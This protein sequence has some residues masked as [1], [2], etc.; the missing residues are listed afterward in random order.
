MKTTVLGR[1]S[2]LAVPAVGLG[3]MG[4]VSAYSPIP[5]RRDMVRFVRE[6]VG[7]GAAF[8][9]TAE[10]YGPYTSEEILGEALEGVRENLWVW[11]AGPKPF[12]KRSRD[13]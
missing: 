12:G 4:M 1:K 13:P 3:C 10:V 9:D 11:T 5:D 8:F 6:A 2:T 7:Q